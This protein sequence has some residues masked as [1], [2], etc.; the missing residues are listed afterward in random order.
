MKK[1]DCLGIDKNGAWQ[2]L[3]TNYDEIAE[4]FEPGD[5][6]FILNSDDE[7]VQDLK[8]CVYLDSTGD[9]LGW[10]GFKKK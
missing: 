10:Y 2:V 5:E 3:E 8:I 4:D 9:R 7:R 6:L 1:A